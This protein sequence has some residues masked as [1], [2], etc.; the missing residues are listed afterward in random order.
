MMKTR[1]LISISATAALAIVA[2]A[3]S[4]TYADAAMD[5]CIEAFVA[6]RVPKDRA[7]RVRKL[8]GSNAHTTG[9]QRITLTAKGSKSGTEIA[10]ATC[11]VSDRGDSV[12]LQDT[13]ESSTL[14]ASTLPESTTLSR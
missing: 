7:V 12:L 2:V 9:T 5:A 8:S 4:A 10:S 11:V 3:P 6:E 1:K 14:A 13:R